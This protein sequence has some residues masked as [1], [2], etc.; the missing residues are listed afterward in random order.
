MINQDIDKGKAFDWGQTSEDYAKFRDI[1][2]NTFY[3]KLIDMGL[4]IEGQRVLDIGTG[5]GVL[6]RNLYKYGSE[7]V[8]LDSSENQIKQARK[9]SEEAGM[10]ISYV[11]SPAESADFPANHFDV[12][13]ACQCYIYFDKNTLFSKISSI[14]KTPGHFCLL[15]M[16]W[17]P[18]ENSI[19]NTSEELILKYNP[20]WSAYGMKPFLYDFPEQAHALFEVEHSFCYD[21][22]VTFTRESWHGRIKT[23]R[24]I[25]A[26][27]LSS[28]EIIAFEEEHIDCLRCVPETF[29]IPHFVTVLNM[30]K[31]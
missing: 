16:G 14:L 22:P 19:A 12:V 5:T 23:C 4:C 9:L 31:K 30:R 28:K 26:S 29:V 15:Y 13:T 20:S 11:V 6:P 27:S 1:Y 18:D 7:F 17:I 24:G 25:G 10:N 8:G 21:I 3:E 2:P